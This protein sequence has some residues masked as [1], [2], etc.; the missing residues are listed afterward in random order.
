MLLE[1]G[2]D[3]NQQD[4]YGWTPLIKAAHEGHAETVS[5]LLQAPEIDPSIAD[6]HGL[7]AL[8][9]AAMGGHQQIVRELLGAGADTA[10]RDARGKQAQELAA[11]AG[12]D[13]VA[14][15]LEAQD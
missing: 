11:E 7:N 8:H 10:A 4:I 2:A 12:H 1:H 5:R 13:A 15:L 9:H 3:S 6:E 14:D